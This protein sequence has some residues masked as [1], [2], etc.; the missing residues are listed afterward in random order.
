LLRKVR[1]P[2]W[3]SPKPDFSWCSPPQPPRFQRD[4]ESTQR[5]P[6]II[7]DNVERL[8]VRIASQEVLLPLDLLAEGH[9][10]EVVN[11]PLPVVE[12]VKPEAVANPVAIPGVEATHDAARMIHQETTDK[13]MLIAQSPGREAI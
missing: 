10:M 7:L 9:T 8:D 12:P 6:G 5:R 4:T 13:V 2:S 3:Q 11:P 1:L